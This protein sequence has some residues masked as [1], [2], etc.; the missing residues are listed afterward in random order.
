MLD[1]KK[2]KR[3]LSASLFL[4]VHF[5]FHLFNFK[6]P[7]P[8]I[9]FVSRFRSPLLGKLVDRYYDYLI[10]EFQQENISKHERNC[11]IFADY[12]FM[13]EHAFTAFAKDIQKYDRFRVQNFKSYFYTFDKYF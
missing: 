10:G 1:R 13:N 4:N 8:A 7:F 6:V 11:L 2:L 3:F 9:T 12:M 5:T